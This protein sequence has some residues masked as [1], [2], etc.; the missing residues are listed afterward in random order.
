MVKMMVDAPPEKRRTMLAERLTMIASQP[1]EER[2]QSVKGVVMG[3]SKL[4]SKRRSTFQCALAEALT[5]CSAN[6]RES[7]YI[8]RARAGQKISKELDTEIYQ[9]IVNEVFDW[10]QER[11]NM[12][13]GDLEKAH[14]KLNLTKPDFRMML[15]KAKAAL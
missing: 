2:I 9:G 1:E 7:I 10:P 14:E 15:D 5:G 8:G 11:R 3:M 12:I 4:D 13:I 6:E